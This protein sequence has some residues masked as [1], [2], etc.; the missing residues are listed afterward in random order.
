VTVYLEIE[1]RPRK[2][3]LEQNASGAWSAAVDGE[4]VMADAHLLRP[5]LLSLILD[6]RAYRLVLEESPDETAVHLGA[7]RFGYRLGDPR[8]LRSRRASQDGADGPKTLKASMPGRVVRVL[9]EPGEAVK[10]GQGVL[11]IEAMKMQNEVKSPKDGKL[12]RLQ[13]KPGDTVNA[14]QPLAVVE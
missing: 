13:V 10:A 1:G 12:S 6:G 14:G 3:Q 2:V 9:V 7:R 4:P 11:V 5:G 8:S